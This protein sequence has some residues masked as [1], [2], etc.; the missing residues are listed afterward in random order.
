M[1]R[2]VR[3]MRMPPSPNLDDRK[4]CVRD[5]KRG[6]KMKIMF[7]HNVRR[8]CRSGLIKSPKVIEN[9]LRKFQD[10]TIFFDDLHALPLVPPN[11]N[12]DSNTDNDEYPRNW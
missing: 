11:E 5:S 3:C 12:E 7:K 4:S 1:L 2:I 10:S 8:R 9:G 6:N